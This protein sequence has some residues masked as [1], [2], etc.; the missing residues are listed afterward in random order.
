MISLMSTDLITLDDYL[1]STGA[2]IADTD[3]ATQS[4]ITWAIT[5]A[6]QAV[7]SYVDRDFTLN[8]DAVQAPRSYRYMGAHGLEIDD[9]TSINSVS[10]AANQFQTGRVLDSSEW[11]ASAIENP[12]GVLDSIELYT[13]LSPWSGAGSPEMGFQRNLD[14]YGAVPYPVVMTV[15]AVWGWPAI[16]ANVKEAVRLTVADYIAD[17]SPYNSESIAAYSRSWSSSRTGASMRPINA[18]PDRALSMLDPYLRIN[19]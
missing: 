5:A 7:R 12:D 4:Q 18:L 10:L 16:P 11:F 9:A 19:V 14:T 15:D 3:P 8:A 2:V 13:I 17:P 6:S 1:A